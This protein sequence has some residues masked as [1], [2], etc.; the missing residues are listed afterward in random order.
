VELKKLKH[1]G[2]YSCASATYANPTANNSKVDISVVP[3]AHINAS[4]Y[5]PIHI[6]IKDRKSHTPVP[7]S[8]S[9]I[10][11]A[12]CACSREGRGPLSPLLVL[13]HNRYSVVHFESCP[14]RTLANSRSHEVAQFAPAEGFKVVKKKKPRKTSTTTAQ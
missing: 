1:S 13:F 14:H 9:P 4:T 8:L 10:A 12:A 3:L 5:H 7:T 2:R 6:T 11:A